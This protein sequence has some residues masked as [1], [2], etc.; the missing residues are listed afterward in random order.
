MHTGWANVDGTLSS[1]TVTGICLMI[2]CLADVDQ[3]HTGLM[4]IPMAKLDEL[5]FMDKPVVTS[6]KASWMALKRVAP[7]I[8]VAKAWAV[9]QKADNDELMRHDTAAHEGEITEWGSDKDWRAAAE[10][11]PSDVP[12]ATMMAKR[13]S[14]AMAVEK[15]SIHSMPSCAPGAT[16]STVDEWTL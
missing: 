7:A 14:L 5:N 10:G 13:S 9:S 16:G 6:A 1:L 11:Q 12:M 2:Y 3:T 15:F 4:R 8:R